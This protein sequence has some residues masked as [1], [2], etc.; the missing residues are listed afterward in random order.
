MDHIVECVPNFSE[1]RNPATMQ[2]LIDALVSVPGVRLLDHTSDCDHHR[3]VMTVVG[4][5]EEMIEAMFRAIRIATGLIDLRKHAGVHPRVGAT[6]VV[7]FIPIKGVSMRDC[8]QAAR[9]LG[10]RV[11]TELEV[12]VFLYERAASHSDHAPLESVR[13]GGLE[14]LAFRMAS[15]PDWAP[16]FGPSRLHETA[17]AIIIGAR[18]ALI[19]FN[20][21]LAS[22]DLVLARSIARSVRQSNGGLRHLKA[23]GVE[24]P[25]RRLVQVAMN[26]TDYEVTPLHMAFKAVEAEAARHG[27]AL[28]GTEIVGLVPEAAVTEV[29]RDALHLTR[30]DR[31][32]VLEAR[33]EAVLTPAAKFTAGHGPRK[34]LLRVSISEFAQ[35]VAAPTAVPAGAAVAALTGALAAALGVMAARLSRQPSAERHLEEIVRRLHHLLLADGAAYNTFV[36]ATKLPETDPGR[37]IAVSSALHVATEIPLEMAERSLE[38]AALLAASSSA[39]KPRLRSDVQV[40]LI[41]AVAAT[42]ACLHTTK[43]NMTIQVNQRLRESLTSRMQT[44]SQN[45]EELRALCYTPPP[46]RSGKHSV[47]ASPGKAQT[48]DEWKSKSSTT[49]SRKPS[50]SRRKNWREKGSSES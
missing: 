46:G 40:G 18:P 20:V 5:P 21:D 30:L 27:V 24:L 39:A 29:A 14:G 28:A 41:L 33:M 32:Q 7:P 44:V 34:D 15:D 47:Q 3:S 25:S 16:D 48:R 12:P 22:T 1:G 6:D 8:V 17:G 23:I 43:E 31:M 10:Q 13:R 19:A 9:R 26:L 42:E 50:K 49:M 45:V 11:G 2:A 35:A 38:A 4:G 37:P 36:A